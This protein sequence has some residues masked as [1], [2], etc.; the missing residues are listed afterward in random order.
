[1]SQSLNLIP[2]ATQRRYALRRVSRVWLTWLAASGACAA[3][4]LGVEWLRG[5]VSLRELM[6]LDARYAPFL[7]LTEEREILAVKIAR[8]RL[9]EENALQISHDE[10]G[11]TLLG[12][13]SRA[14]ANSG[15]NVY[16]DSLAYRRPTS[17]P[18][19]A[20][21]NTVQ[22]NGNTVQLSGVGLDGMSVAGFAA[23][24]RESGVFSELTVQNT[25]PIDGSVASLRQFSIA[26]DL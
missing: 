21:T 22:N 26:G 18:A 24:L 3:M 16:L 2:A 8:L 6:D 19:N 13:L 12:V 4:I 1:M 9:R 15:G 17:Q 11:M 20:S 23:K 10:H 5:V 7:H 14:A 25:Q